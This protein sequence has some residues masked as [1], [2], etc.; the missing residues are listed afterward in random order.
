MNKNKNKAMKRNYTQAPLPFQGQKRRFIK[1]FKQYLNEFEND[2]VFVDLFGGSGLLSHTAKQVHPKAKVIYNDFDN[3]RERL[4]AVD[5]TNAILSMLRE[6]LKDCPAD[7]RIVG[8]P[9]ERV[10]EIL[11]QADKEGYVDW[12]TLSSSLMFSMNYG[13]CLQD[14]ESSSLYNSVR[15]SNYVTDG[16]L[17]GVEV[18]SLDYKQL[19]NLCKDMSKVV[20]FVD[21]PYLSTDSSTYNSD[22]YW[23]LKDYLDVLQVVHGQD[24]FYFTSNKSQIVELCE[25]ISTVSAQANPFANAERVAVNTSTN[26]NA[27]YVDIMYYYKGE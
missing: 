1:L 9:K 11:R 2:T 26:H 25:W 17:D 6:V 5:I 10:L 12:I 20:F 14:F 27:K 21:P 7:K 24:Y 13:T 8:A 16:Y 18:V 22:G 3:Y 23:K 19:F 15:Q 4:A